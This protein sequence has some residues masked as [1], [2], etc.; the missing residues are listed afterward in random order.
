M[1]TLEFGPEATLSQILESM[2]AAED[3]NLEVSLPKGS[4]LLSNTINREIIEKFAKKIG[5]GVAVKSASLVGEEEPEDFD[6]VEGEDILAKKTLELGEG[7][8]L[9]PSESLAEE[10]VASKKTKLCAAASF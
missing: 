8:V 3:E 10:P 6:F 7:P 2:K 9:A 1:K 4:T 5:K